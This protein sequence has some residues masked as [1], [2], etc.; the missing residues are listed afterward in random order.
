MVLCLGTFSFI[1]TS[2]FYYGMPRITGREWHSQG[3][4]R[5]HWWLKTIGFII[6][7]SSLTVA[8]LVQAAGWNFGIPVDQWSLAIRPY[9]AIRAFSGVMIFLGQV[10]FAYNVYKTLYS[11]EKPPLKVVKTQEVTA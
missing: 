2:A 1:L 11:P 3:L 6:M 9:W 4:I 8:G 5:A 10:L 7:M